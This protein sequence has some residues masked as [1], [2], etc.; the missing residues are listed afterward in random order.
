VSLTAIGDSACRSLDK[1]SR[2]D[3]PAAWA[4]L[5]QFVDLP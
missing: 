2:L 1:T 5:G 3:T 4:F